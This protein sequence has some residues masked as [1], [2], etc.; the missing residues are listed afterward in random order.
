MIPVSRSDIC[1][2]CIFTE[3][4]ERLGYAPHGDHG[5]Q[6]EF[7][8]HATDFW[9]LEELICEVEM[10]AEKEEQEDGNGNVR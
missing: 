8:D 9:E 4:C 7:C 1:S 5:G 10:L 3:D 6:W 2:M